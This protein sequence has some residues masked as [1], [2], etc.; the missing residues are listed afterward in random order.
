MKKVVI[1]SAIVLLIL[2]N[3]VAY[4]LV[5]KKYNDLIDYFNQ[6]SQLTGE[7]LDGFDARIKEMGARIDE[8]TAQ[9][10]TKTGSSR[11]QIAAAFSEMRGD[12]FSKIE[13]L[14]GDVAMIR[15]KLGMKTQPPKR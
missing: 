9:L 11:E 1:A 4:L 6:D 10:D 7:R 3:T 14:E 2:L 5:Y 13:S 12:L 8:V 15:Q